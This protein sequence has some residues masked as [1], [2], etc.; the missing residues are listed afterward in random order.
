MLLYWSL[1][2][3]DK[4]FQGVWSPP[5]QPEPAHKNGPVTRT[6]VQEAFQAVHGGRTVV[7]GTLGLCSTGQVGRTGKDTSGRCTFC[8]CCGLCLSPRLTA[9]APELEN[10]SQKIL[11]PPS[12]MQRVVPEVTSPSLHISGTLQ[13]VLVCVAQPVRHGFSGPK[14]Q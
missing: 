9:E 12:L 1:D 10:L 8:F 11:L 4:C 13:N 2:S 5:G 3:V 7:A 14:A 6:T